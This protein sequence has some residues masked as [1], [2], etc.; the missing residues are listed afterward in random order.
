MVALNSMNIAESKKEM[1]KAFT[2]SLMVRE[3]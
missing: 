3:H 1:L 2:D